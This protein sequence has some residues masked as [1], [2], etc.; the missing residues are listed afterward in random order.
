MD[1]THTFYSTGLSIAVSTHGGTT[2]LRVAQRLLSWEFLQV[3]GLFVL[4]L[5]GVGTLVWLCERQR[6]PQQFGQGVVSGIG[7][8]FWCA[9]VTMTTV[10]YGD[11]AP[12]T[13]LGRV[14]AL[15]WMFMPLTLVASFIATI[16]SALTVTELAT[17]IG[18]PAD[19]I[20]RRIATV[21]GSTSAAYLRKQAI[22]PHTFPTP[23]AG[24][25]A[26]ANGNMDAMVY[27]AP[28]LRYLT[29]TRFRG[30]IEVLPITLERQDYG[31]A[32]PPGS[33]LREPIN[34]ALLEIISQPIWQEILDR[35]LG[36]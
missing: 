32:L 21:P 12:V 14:L 25:Q 35:Y 18:Q 10:G 23:Q 9:A 17:Y 8:G 31:I 29:K 26:V 34:R 22:T 33:P 20:R 4:V 13:V 30:A 16:T 5:S 28:L 2:W 24:L 3:I 27:D 19:L 6:N 1:F 15:I 11:K 7:A 36:K